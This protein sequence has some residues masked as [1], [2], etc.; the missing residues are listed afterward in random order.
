MHY[1]YILHAPT[2]D[3]YYI[4]QTPDLETR[5][6]FHNKLSQK[7]YTSKYRPWVLKRAIAVENQSIAMKMERYIKNRKSRVY[8][9]K[10]IHQDDLVEKLKGRFQDPG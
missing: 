7:S 10:L 9:E 4:G 6:L 5:M 3:K 2:H 8:L 1:V